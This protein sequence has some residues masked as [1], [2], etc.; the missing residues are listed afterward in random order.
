MTIADAFL[1]H[2]QIRRRDLWSA[3][4]I[5]RGERKLLRSVFLSFL[6]RGIAR[7]NTSVFFVY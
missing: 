7:G 6:L 4:K 1:D 3:E 5:K 2:R